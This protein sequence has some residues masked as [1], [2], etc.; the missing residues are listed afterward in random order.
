MDTVFFS[1]RTHSR[2]HLVYARQ[3]GFRV[4]V[5]SNPQW[6]GF[7]APRAYRD[8][9]SRRLTALGV[10]REQCDVQFNIEKLAAQQA[11]RDPNGYVVE[12]FGWW[13]RSNA[14]RAT[15]WTFE[16]FQGGALYTAFRHPNL[17]GTVLVPQ[18]Y[19]D[20]MGRFDSFGVVRDLVD[21]GAPFT[22]VLPFYDAAEAGVRG[23]SGF[24]Y[25]QNRLPS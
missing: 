2:A 15:S 11:G 16:G 3:N 9:V 17:T 1:E 23:A 19:D 25:L 13:R 14:A 10:N 7:P 21:W 6:Y 22:R 4:G 5:Y 8:V 20:R 12:L 24:F 18:A